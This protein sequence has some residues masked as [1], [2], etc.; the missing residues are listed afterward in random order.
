MSAKFDNN[1]RLS[2]E[3]LEGVAGGSWQE[4]YFQDLKNAS[5]RNME[6][7]KG[8]DP[9]NA[10]TAVY[11]LQNWDKVVGQL[12]DMFARHGIEMTYKGKPNEDNIYTYQGKT[13]TREEAWKIIDGK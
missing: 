8:M 6:G 7:F 13:I 12:K 10:D 1:A 5:D 9:Y 11:C 4:S 3:Q 2:T